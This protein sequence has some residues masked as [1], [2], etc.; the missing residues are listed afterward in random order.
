MAVSIL[1]AD[2]DPVIHHI[3]GSVLGAAGH[4][5]ELTK[6]GGEFLAVLRARAAAGRTPALIFLDL[7]LLDMTAAEILPEIRTAV[8]SVPV[9]I[10]SANSE[11]ETRSLF[12]GLDF[13]G[14]L[15]KPFTPATLLETIERLK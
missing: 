3:V 6:S 5:V 15:E 14:Y 11:D 12:P 7:Q 1:I 4:D 2:D 13:Q 10:V 9:V 8:G